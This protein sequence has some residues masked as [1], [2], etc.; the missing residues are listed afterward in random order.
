MWASVVVVDTN[1]KGFF[2]PA[3]GRLELKLKHVARN[4]AH[5]LL[6]ENGLRRLRKE[7]VACPKNDA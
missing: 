7:Q 4:M 2:D 6:V 3:D 5:R 1:R